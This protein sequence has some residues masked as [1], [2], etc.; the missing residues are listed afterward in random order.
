MRS[1]NLHRFSSL[2]SLNVLYCS[3]GLRRLPRVATRS[4]W[5]CL[6]LTPCDTS[7]D[8]I[9]HSEVCP[10]FD[11]TSRLLMHIHHNDHCFKQS[12]VYSSIGLHRLPRVATRSTWAFLPSFR[13]RLQL[14]ISENAIVFI[15]PNSRRC[16]PPTSTELVDCIY[17]F[18]GFCFT[19]DTMWYELWQHAILRCVLCVTWRHVY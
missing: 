4:T 15:S 9:R 12:S 1:S 13:A 19:S 18:L 14:D 6:L 17:P 11:L 2:S 10:L 16:Y 3:I 7:Y 8:N 5:N